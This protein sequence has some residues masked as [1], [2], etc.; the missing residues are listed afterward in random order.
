MDRRSGP[1]SR[2]GLALGLVL[3]GYGRAYV[4][5]NVGSDSKS[6]VIYAAASCRKKTTSLEKLSVFFKCSSWETGAYRFL[7]SEELVSK[8]SKVSKVKKCKV[9]NCKVS[10]QMPFQVKA[11]VKIRV[12][13]GPRYE[14]YFV[15]EEGGTRTVLFLSFWGWDW[16]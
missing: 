3:F 15:C 12:E 6:N 4:N 14:L 16:K 7:I 13:L 9:K 2:S 10:T 5:R 1:L 8:V 11:P